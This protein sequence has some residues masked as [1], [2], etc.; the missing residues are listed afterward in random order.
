MPKYTLGE[1]MS[2]A[3]RGVGQ[4]A[5]IP[6]SVVSFYVNAAY[7][8]VAESSDHALLEKHVFF[9]LR[10]G[11]STVTLPND[12]GTPISFS[13]RTTSGNTLVGTPLTQLSALDADAGLN[14]TRG[15]PRG[16]VLYGNR[17]E[18]H[19]AP[20]ASYSLSLRY[21]ST[22]TDLVEPSDVPSVATR[23]RHGILERTKA[24]LFEDIGNF[25][26]ASAQ[27]ARYVSYMMAQET[28]VAKRQ[29]TKALGGVRVVYNSTAR[30]SAE[31]DYD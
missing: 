9:P 26:E 15:E 28:D 17:V 31:F 25:E 23:F 27:Q 10:A 22:I 1:I 19:P 11:D 20:D 7:M 12:F 2:M 16:Y 6:E 18:L 3:T 14:A 21:E 5:D 30:R 8:E 29:K 24:H 13:L 4:R